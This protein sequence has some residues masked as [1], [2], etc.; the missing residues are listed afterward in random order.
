M[1]CPAECQP[2]RITTPAVQAEC[3][4]RDA[5]QQLNQHPTPQKRSFESESKPKVSSSRREQ[6]G[7]Q[8]RP[9]SDFF[10]KSRQQKRDERQ[11]H[12]ADRSFDQHP[13]KQFSFSHAQM[14]ATKGTNRIFTSNSFVLFVLLCDWFWTIP[15][16]FCRMPLVPQEHALRAL[17]M[18][19]PIAQLVEQLAF[20]QWVAG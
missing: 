8:Q 13:P 2:L 17:C 5:L 7:R 12:P 9:P 16:S 6:H 11:H 1:Q 4:K 10:P 14:V 3:S 15:R 19:G 18:Y 20:N